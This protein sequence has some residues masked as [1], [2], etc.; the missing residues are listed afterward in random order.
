MNIP[1]KYINKNPFKVSIFLL[2]L[3][4]AFVPLVSAQS[5]SSGYPD[6]SHA[7]SVASDSGSYSGG[8]PS[9]G[10]VVSDS[11]GSKNPIGVAGGHYY[12]TV[13][14]ITYEYNDGYYKDGV[15]YDNSGSD[16]AYSNSGSQSSGIVSGEVLRNQDMPLANI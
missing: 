13:G 10:G 4:I 8:S 6:S 2:I 9:N 11:Y 16:Q 15:F 3:C 5:F 7:I 12:R 1:N 14:E